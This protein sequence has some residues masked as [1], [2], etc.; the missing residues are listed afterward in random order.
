MTAMVWKRGLWKLHS[1]KTTKMDYFLAR[2]L[3]YVVGSLAI[4]LA[5]WLVG[6]IEV[7]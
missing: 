4:L 7:V 6:W 5:R 3:V 1:T 2:F